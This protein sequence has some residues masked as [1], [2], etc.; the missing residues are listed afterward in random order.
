MMKNPLSNPFSAWY[1]EKITGEV[2]DA[3]LLASHM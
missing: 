1:P 2:L 3:I